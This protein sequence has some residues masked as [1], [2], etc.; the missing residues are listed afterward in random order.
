M[1]LKNRGATEKDICL[2]NWKWAYHTSQKDKI[3]WCYDWLQFDLERAY[4]IYLRKN[5]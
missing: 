2:K 3:S 5:S 1:L 4:I